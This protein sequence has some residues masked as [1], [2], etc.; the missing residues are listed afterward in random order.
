[1]TDVVTELVFRWLTGPDRLG[2]VARTFV[3]RFG[4]GGGQTL[5]RTLVDADSGELIDDVWLDE[6]G[7]VRVMVG[8]EGAPAPAMSDA[9]D[10]GDPIGVELVVAT[11]AGADHCMVEHGRDDRLLPRQRE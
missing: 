7:R 1:V 5:R 4:R 11:S 8:A 9:P 3:W 6:D 10:R 2:T